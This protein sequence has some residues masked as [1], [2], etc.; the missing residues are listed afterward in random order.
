MERLLNENEVVAHACCALRRARWSII[1][2][3]TTRDHGV[4]IIAER[5]G[6]RLYVEAK[7]V[8]SANQSSNRFGA[9][10]TSSQIFI[11]VA[12]ALLKTAELRSMYPDAQVGIAAPEHGAMRR[13]LGG[14]TSVLLGARI[15][16]LWVDVEGDVVGW[17]TTVL[18]KK[19]GH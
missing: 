11:Q 4:D 7:G 1:Q 14:I 9:V 5:H 19:D 6:T 16:V 12:A 13:R 3:A 17:N 18:S 8:T 10:Q 2:A 15:G